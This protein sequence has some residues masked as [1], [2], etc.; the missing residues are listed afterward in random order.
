MVL[1][2]RSGAYYWDVTRRPFGDLAVPDPISIP[3]YRSRGE[4]TPP[5]GV[6]PQAEAGPGA[7]HR[8]ERYLASAEPHAAVE[9]ARLCGHLPL[10]VRIVGARLAAPIVIVLLVVEVA[11]GLISRS[12]P[13]LNFMIIGYPV[14]LVIGLFVLAAVVGTVPSVT[15]AMLESVLMLAMRTAAIFR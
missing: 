12:S 8:A 14:R 1:D 3:T 7:Q 15:N 11:V 5:I 13:S 9:I 10:A 2:G 4:P 6:L